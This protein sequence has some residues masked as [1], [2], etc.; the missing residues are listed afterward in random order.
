MQSGNDQTQP[1]ASGEQ[2]N[3]P[4]NEEEKEEEETPAPNRTNVPPRNR[5][6]SSGNIDENKLSSK[7]LDFSV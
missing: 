7:L 4:S 2:Q 3:Q 5:P 1:E 6:G